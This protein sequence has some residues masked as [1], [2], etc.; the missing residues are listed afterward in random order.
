MSARL[1][2]TAMARL[3]EALELPPHTISLRLEFR[4][5]A[6][7]SM[8]VERILTTE[9]IEALAEWYETEG[10]SAFQTAETTYSL[11]KREPPAHP[12]P[13]PDGTAAA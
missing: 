8:T 10:V 13:A 1:C 11:L 6:M 4:P 3:L 2:Q 5:H 12:A 7:A 9:E